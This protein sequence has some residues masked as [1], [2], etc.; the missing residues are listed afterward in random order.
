[1]RNL[2]SVVALA[3]A[4][5]ATTSFAGDQQP[6]QPPSGQ[7]DK[8]GAQKGQMDHSKMAS[9]DFASLDK[10]K[11]GKLTQDEVPADNPLSAHFAM[12]DAD[13]N[14]TLSKAEFGKAQSMK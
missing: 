7:Y 1:M 4:L 11:D 10:N 5:V 12:L 2:I 3:T 9:V 6:A 13:K 14:G 8:S